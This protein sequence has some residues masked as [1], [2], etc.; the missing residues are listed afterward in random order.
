MFMIIYKKEKRPLLSSKLR[1]SPFWFFA[2]FAY[3]LFCFFPL[4][5]TVQIFTGND[6]VQTQPKRAQYIKS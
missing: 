5:Q 4:W 6:N 3:K 2:L 1:V